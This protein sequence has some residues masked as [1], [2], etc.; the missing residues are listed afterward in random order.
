MRAAPQGS[1][2]LR[3]DGQYES[4][5]LK[6]LR[7]SN[8][9]TGD[10]NARTS[11]SYGQI[12]KSS[13]IIGGSAAVNMII[14]M[15]SA[16][17]GAVF[18][19][20]DGVGLLKIY[21]STLAMVRTFSGLGIG[22]SGVREIADAIGSKDPNRIGSTVQILRKMCWLTGLL[23]WLFSATIA[24][25]LSIWAFASAD[26]TG[27][28]VILG[29]TIL[30]GAI[31]SGQVAFLQGSRRIADMAKIN[32]FSAMASTAISIA[33]YWQF[34]TGGIVP[35]LALGA[36]VTVLISWNYARRIAVPG[37]VRV[38][39]LQAIKSSKRLVS[40]G[41][42][43]MWSGFLTSIVGI[44]TNALIVRN[45]GM[46][47]NG[48]YGAAWALSGMFANFILGAMGADFCPRLTSVQNDHTMVSK[49]VNEQT[50]IGIL[51]ALPGLIATLFFAPLAI[52]LFYTSEFLIAAELLPFLILGV[53]GRITSWPMGFVLIAKGASTWYAATETISN[54]VYLG[55]LT[56]G[57]FLFG[58]HGLAAS[59]FIL[60]VGVNIIMYWLLRRMIRF[61]WRASVWRLLGVGF[62][63]VMIAFILPYFLSEIQNYI[64]GSFFLL[65]ATLYSLR[66]LALRLGLDHR[67]IRPI[68]K[69]PGATLFFRLG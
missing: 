63:L 4:A 11:S 17:A 24:Y 56:L 32:V 34:G 58:L 55:L 46:E 1:L 15:A 13:S 29:V 40:L 48:Y 21:G 20:P 26:Y 49:L 69:M 38:S 25:P 45:L 14:G 23:G 31:S 8:K 37:Q 35:G 53:F 33:L 41:I 10:T 47:A 22:A 39:W 65:I 12:L 57:L 44:V 5:L 19:G 16:K 68:L 43:F 60:Y 2:N 66:G 50:E 7:M 61:S 64:A 9:Q 67:F 28:L 54:L 18:L 42:A 51:L 27:P 36:A 59:F 3:K 6:R 62:F 30:L 52:K